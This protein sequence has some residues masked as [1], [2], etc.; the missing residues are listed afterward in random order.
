MYIDPSG[1]DD[2]IIYT[3]GKDSDFRAQA[4]YMKNKLTEE[5]R[6]VRMIGIDATNGRQEFET[7]WNSL[8]IDENGNGY[9]L[10]NV[11]IYS[12]GNERSL[13]LQDGSPLE[14][15]SINGKNSSGNEIGDINSLAHKDIDE[16]YLYS[17]NA[18]NV[19]QYFYGYKIIDPDTGLSNGS[20]NVA[21][22]FSTKITGVVYGYDGSV[23]FGPSVIADAVGNYEPRLSN[24]QGHYNK[25]RYDVLPNNNINVVSPSA[26][27]GAIAYRNGRIYIP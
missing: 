16:L 7:A 21:S 17:C 6:T 24:D 20:G 3:H 5:D 2:V 1:L 13:I 4:L 8:G 25:I 14:A 10:D 23:S 18:G 11:Y 9:E 19:D 26:P 27:M 22:I 12:H 15:L